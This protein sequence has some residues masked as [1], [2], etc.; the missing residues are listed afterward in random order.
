MSGAVVIGIATALAVWWVGSDAS[1]IAA[2]FVLLWIASPAIARW[3]SVSP[4]IAGRLAASDTD[5]KALRLIARRTWRYFETFVTAA[6]HMLPPDNF[7]EDPN[8]V[9]AHRTSPTNLGLYFLSTVSACDFG[10]VGR[11]ETVDR[12]EATIA[13]MNSLEQFHGHFYNWYDTRD[14]RPLDP[15]YVSSVDSGN[16]AGHLIAL[17]NACRGWIG[18][19][20]AGP[21]AF[22][23]IEDALKLTRESLQSIPDDRRVQMT[24][25]HELERALDVLA[26][27]LSQQRSPPQASAVQLAKLGTGAATVVDIAR[28]LAGER[29]DDAGA[30]MLF[31]AEATQRSIES[32]RRNVAHGI[33]AVRAL[34]QRLAAL[35]TMAQA[36]AE[37]MDF[38]FLFDRDRKLLSIG[39]LVQEGKLD[40]SCYDLLASERNSRAS[41]RSP[42]ATC[43]LGTGFGSGRPSTPINSGAALISWS[44][45]MFEYLMPSLVMR[46]PAGSLLEQTSRLVVRRQ[47]AYG[48][49]L[50]LPWGMSESAYNVRD[51][52]LTYQYSNFGVPGLGLKRGLGE[53][54]VVAPYATAL[55]TMVDPGA[56][57]K[58]FARLARLGAL[59]RYGF[60]EA[61]DFTRTRLPEGKDVAV[62]R[63]FLAH[64][65]G[66]TVVA[67][68][69]ALLDAQMRTR[70]HAEPIVQATELLLQERTPRDVAEVQIRAEA[71]KTGAA[72]R[73]L[74]LSTVRRLRSAQ[75]VT[76][77]A[78]LLSNGRYAVMLTAAGSGYSRWRDLAVT[79]WREDATRD[80]WGAYV[81]LRDVQNGE[82]WSAGY[83]PSGVEPRSYN[84]AFSEDRAE[85]VRRDGT[86]TT[87]LEILVSP[88]DDAEVRRVT[89]ANA[90]I[91]AR[92]IELTSY[93]ELVLA[94]PAADATH[95]AFSK[96]FVQTEYLAKLG[97]ILATRQRRSPTEPEVWAAHLA[98][99]EGETMGEQEIET[100]RAHFL[101]RGRD[102][103][104][105]IAVIDGRPLSNSVGTV[106]DPIFA[107]RRRVRIPP[108]GTVRIAFWTV[109]ASSRSDVLDMIDKHHDANAFERAATLAW[110]QAQVQ[111]S[112]LGVDADEA[113]LF[114]RLAGH[115][116][117]ANSSMRA[118]SDA[119]RRGGGK[120]SGLWPQSISGDLP[121]V[122][123]RIDAIEDIAIVGQLLRAHEYWR[124]KQLAVDLVIL[125]DRAA[126]YVQDLQTALETIVRSHSR[127]QVGGTPARGSVFMLRTALLAE[128]TRALLLS[129][130]RVVLVGRRGSLSDQINR[131][132][133]PRRAAA[134][135]A[136][137]TARANVSS[138][139]SATPG[140]PAGPGVLQWAWRI[141]QGRPRICDDPRCRANDTGP[142]AQCRCQPVVRLPGVRRGRRLHMV[143][144]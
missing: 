143:A 33:D 62:V 77:E 71:V 109:V 100:D 97:T 10:W 111:L 112:H 106:L 94:T 53:S 135:P 48:T 89:L 131:L 93:S 40:P 103:R 99:V 21:E 139:T 56:A 116:L 14:L 26:A 95:P 36:I 7:Q 69:N 90:G 124:M 47:K 28:T 20:M 67:I 92:D 75:D 114:Q 31:W 25:R 144:Q 107:L 49:A 85:F 1:V 129:V 43:R 102:V 113:A 13:T 44:G 121:I 101:G 108:R 110:T 98:V 133:A 46:A 51:L 59:G 45:S 84:V 3:A 50:G 125:N 91:R 63:A 66:M 140:I 30:E 39:Y 38:G 132:A 5:A 138:A 18:R 70:F 60:Y 57:M 41:W 2:P 73:D 115:V 142:V 88:E 61:L 120:Q 127:P 11:T 32:H 64:H 52:E 24:T 82:V 123:V 8:P 72:I 55:A 83:Q 23:G 78:H 12:L 68:A 118:S 80:D 58:N 54:A 76:P 15:Q 134:P 104:A 19:P 141:C 105:P 4:R 65:Q 81:Y 79:R 34:D 136:K 87:T 6:D 130:A 96:L 9:L 37:E 86:I 137:R 27:A 29:G 117:Y 126:S 22:A 16:L 74:K 17:A 35:E 42:R 122:L 128:E 119:I